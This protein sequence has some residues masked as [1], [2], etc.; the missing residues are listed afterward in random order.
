MIRGLALLFCLSVLVAGCGDG[1]PAADE[2]TAANLSQ[3][4]EAAAPEPPPAPE[5][6]TVRVRLETG[7]GPITLALDHRHAPITTENFLRYVDAGRF[8]DIRF[9]RAARPAGTTG[10]GFIQ[11]GIQRSY[12]RMYAPIAHEPTSKTGLSHG[13]GAISM[14]RLAPGTAA[15]E[16]I[17]T[18]TAL[19]GLDADRGDPGF[20]A[21]GRVTEGMDVVR[22]ILAAPTIPNAGRGPMKGQMIKE[23][24]KIVSARRVE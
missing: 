10:A 13:A 15:G 19:P 11:G 6:D 20:A 21:F 9:Y 18:A 7:E 5:A 24:V 1:P 14:A 4:E 23:Q 22:R 17:I 16:F 12:R 2:R 8:D 3:A